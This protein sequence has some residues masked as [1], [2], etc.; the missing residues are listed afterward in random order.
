M[1]C[2]YVDTTE[3]PSKPNFDRTVLPSAPRAAT[4]VKVDLSRLPS[5]PPYTVYLGN[6]AYDCSEE[7]IKEFFQ[8]KKVQVNPTKI[9]PGRNW[10]ETYGGLAVASH[11]VLHF[12][13]PLQVSNVRLPKEGTTNRPKGF[14]YAE[15]GTR[16]DLEEALALTGE[17]CGCGQERRW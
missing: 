7:D 12:S 1:L 10:R 6:L 4:A 5:N 2:C 13:F 9:S 11:H 8:R 17:V 3:W 14:G 15:L 16:Q